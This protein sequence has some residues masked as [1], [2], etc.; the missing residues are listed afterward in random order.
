MS[1][2]VRYKSETDE[3]AKESRRKK[4]SGIHLS[5]K[6]IASR[7]EAISYDEVQ[8]AAMWDIFFCPTCRSRYEQVKTEYVN[9]N[10]PRYDFVEIAEEHLS[11]RHEY[12]NRVETERMNENIEYGVPVECSPEEELYAEVWDEIQRKRSED[13]KRVLSIKE[14]LG[15]WF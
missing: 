1:R 2:V 9:I 12:Y 15:I 6:E 13:P 7:T 14:R 5:S 10:P 8:R 3:Q 4:N 11:E